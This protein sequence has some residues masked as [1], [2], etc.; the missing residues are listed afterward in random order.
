MK[1]RLT[2]IAVVL[3][4]NAAVAAPDS[5]GSQMYAGGMRSV[6]S[7]NIRHDK[8][9]LLE[10]RAI[11]ERIWFA[12]SANV[13]S[14]YYL[15]YAEYELVRYGMID[16]GSG[17]FDAYVD[18]A[19]NHTQQVLLARPDWSE[20]LA[21]MANIDG[22]RISR[23]WIKGATLG[24]EANR[25]AD[26]AVAADS[27][28]PRAWLVH[29]IMKFNTPEF[30]GGS[31]ETAEQDFRKAIALF[32]NPSQSEPL[33][34]SWGYP[35][36]FAWLGRTLEKLGHPGEARE[37]YQRALAIEPGFSWVSHVL[38]PALQKKMTDKTQ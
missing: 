16:E 34:Q 29:G 28:N 21:L 35:E 22:I 17:F 38:L 8:G 26:H 32:E 15:S 10:G 23:S 20:A 25:L 19:V 2:A 9:K 18:A 14:L 7:G 36:T 11:L 33:P 37:T 4:T 27:A 3:A 12:D 5:S 1:F 24:P 30:F 6:V 13:L 31:V